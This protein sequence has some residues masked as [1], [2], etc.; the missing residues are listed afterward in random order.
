MESPLLE[1]LFPELLHAEVLA[2]GEADH[3]RHRELPGDPIQ[4]LSASVSREPV[5]LGGRD[6]DVAAEGLG[7]ANHLDVAG[8][9]S[10]LA[11]DQDDEGAA[12]P[13]R[14]APT[15]CRRCCARRRRIPGGRRAAIPAHPPRTSRTLRRARSQRQVLPELR[16]LPPERLRI[17]VRRTAESHLPGGHLDPDPL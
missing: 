3:L 16:E 4:L 1:E 15:T 5:E 17:P 9:R 2:G 11:V 14:S 13:A 7:P 8:L 6:D 12:R 10:E